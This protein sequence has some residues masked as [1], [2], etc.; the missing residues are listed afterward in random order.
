MGQGQP[1]EEGGAPWEANKG[2]GS[3]IGALGPLGDGGA[4]GDG[5]H[6]GQGGDGPR[7]PPWA[8]DTP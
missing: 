4:I 8:P 7:C 5:G 2:R 6:G 1:M 3:P